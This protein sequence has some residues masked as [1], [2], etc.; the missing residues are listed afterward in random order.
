MSYLTIT[1][2]KCR[3]FYKCLRFCPLK[4]IRMRMGT[5]EIIEDRCIFDGQCA[6][7]CPQ[8]AIH[9]ISEVNKVKKYLA[10]GEKVVASISPT[11]ILAFENNTLRLENF[12]IQLGFSAVE[13]MDDA[14]SL[15]VKEYQSLLVKQSGPIISSHCPSICELI[16]KYFPDI[17]CNLAPIADPAMIHARLIKAQN[18]DVHRV[19]HIGPCLSERIREDENLD[20]VLL[21]NEL[22]DWIS[23]AHLELAPTSSYETIENSENINPTSGVIS[24]SGGLLLSLGLFELTNGGRSLSIS[25]IEES[26]E[27]LN[28]FPPKKISLEFVELMACHGGCING[29]FLHIKQDMVSRKFLLSRVNPKI[30]KTPILDIDLSRKQHANPFF[31]PKKSQEEIDYVLRHHTRQINCGICGYNTCYQKAKA[32]CED[33]AD[34]KTCLP[35]IRAQRQETLSILEYSPNGVLL[36]DTD[37]RIRFANPSFYRMFKCVG[38]NLLG[39]PT[40]DFIFSN[41][42]KEAIADAKITTFKRTIPK[43][44]I[45]FSAC[46]FPIKGASLY[47]GIL[48]DISDE[49]AARHEFIKVKDETLHRAQEVIGRQM[50]TAQEIAG[51]LGE[52]T[53]ET[54]V[55]LVKLMNL[56]NK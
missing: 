53:A 39:Q 41:C 23:D 8:G 43:L 19:V 25:G 28:N 9:T 26:L 4:A 18:P 33:M 10:A 38:K 16:E 14:M 21:F 2:A 46:I 6:N 3:D 5:M 51:L 54:K 55:L 29:P 37:T 40:V 27:F 30:L 56:F 7:I 22:S 31:K 34:A 11:A 48:N 20:A 36:V 24:V 13:Y 52:T 1:H 45:S 50:K 47:C 32:V 15:L 42:F 12:L 44:K 35:L 17:V 49:E